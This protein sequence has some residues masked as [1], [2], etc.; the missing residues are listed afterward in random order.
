MLEIMM[1]YLAMEIKNYNNTEEGNEWKRK[2]TLRDTLKFES[3]DWFLNSTTFASISLP[4]Y[5]LTCQVFIWNKRL[6]TSGFRL[7]F[8]VRPAI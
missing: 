3:I 5:H 4:I 1:S 8:S 7:S 6:I 2:K